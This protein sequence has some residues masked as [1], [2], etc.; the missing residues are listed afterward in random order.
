MGKYSILE[1]RLIGLQKGNTV[2][3]ALLDVQD[4]GYISDHIV[5]EKATID[6][7]LIHINK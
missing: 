2:F 6:D 4:M 1:K 7:I 5:V 3:S